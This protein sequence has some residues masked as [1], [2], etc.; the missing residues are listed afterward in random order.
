[1]NIALISDENYAAQSAVTLQSFFDNNEGSH[2]IY[3]ITI[4]ITDE[5]RLKLE[6]LCR[7]HNSIF[8]YKC[9]DEKKLDPFNGIGYWSKYTFMKLFIPELLP[10]DVDKV[11]YLDVDMLIKESLSAIYCINIEGAGVAAVEDVPQ[12]DSHRMRCGLSSEAVYINS[13]TA[14][15]LKWTSRSLKQLKHSL[16]EEVFH[17]RRFESVILQPINGLLYEQKQICV[18]TIG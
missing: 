6:S 13:G 7:E 2:E 12:A 8:H 11:L 14:V 18:R 1:M 9:M 17:V 4:G 15:P 10:S 16:L 5:S 3:F